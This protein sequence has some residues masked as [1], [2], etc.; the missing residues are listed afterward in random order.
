MEAYFAAK[1]L[2]VDQLAPDGVAVVNADDPAW[3]ALAAGA[4][5]GARSDERAHADVR[6]DD[7]RFTSARQ[8]AATLVL[9]GERARGRAAADRRLQRRQRARPPRPRAW[10]LGMPADAIARAAAAPC[11]R[12]RA[13]S[14]SCNERPTVLRDYAHTPDALERALDAVRPFAPD[15]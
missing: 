2:L 7:V 1:A 15:G 3:A 10:A 8:R 6:A 14:R 11:R 12:C 5:H 9:D 4:A 13:G